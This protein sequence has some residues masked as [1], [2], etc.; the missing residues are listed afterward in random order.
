MEKVNSFGYVENN[1]EAGV[2]VR[3]L[4]ALAVQKRFLEVTVLHELVD[5]EEAASF[6]VRGEVRGGDDVARD[7]L[8]G[9]EEL[10]VELALAL[11][12]GGGVHELDRD[13][14]SGEGAGE[15]GTEAAMAEAGGEG[16]GGAP[17]DRKG[18][19]VRGG[20][21]RRRRRVGGTF[22]R[23]DAVAEEEEEKEEGEGGDSGGEERNEKVVVVVVVVMTWRCV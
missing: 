10:V 4:G 13:G 11:V 19:A 21:G 20:G 9:E 16:I 22:A 14:D 23:E 8:G 12:A 3:E 18:E 7:Q 6:G 15:Y 2:P 1:R 5:Q 17:E